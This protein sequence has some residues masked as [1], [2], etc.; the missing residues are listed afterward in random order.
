MSHMDGDL[1]DLGKVTKSLSAED[2]YQLCLG[3]MLRM[4]DA[5]LC[6][7]ELDYLYTDVKRHNCL[8]RMSSP[9]RFTHT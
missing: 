5:C 9:A 7:K 1:I 3:I 8:Y 6:L 2:R 4:I